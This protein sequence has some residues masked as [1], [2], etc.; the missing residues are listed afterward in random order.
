MPEFTPEQIMLRDMVR[1]MAKEKIAPLAAEIDRER[2]YPD[3][4]IV[5]LR[6]QGLFGIP[7]PEE[8]GGGGHGVL[9]SCIVVEELAKVCGNSAMVVA[10]QDLGAIPI[11]LA[12]SEEQKARYLPPLATGEQ[13]ISFALTEPEAGSDVASMRTKAEKKGNEYIINGSKRFISYADVADVMCV[14]AKTNPDGGAR[15][16]SAFIVDA[17]SPGISIGKREDKM[18]FGGFNACEVYFDDVRVPST[19]LLGGEGQGFRLAMLTLD[20]TRP[21]IGAEGVGLAEGCLE[22]AIEYSKQRIQFGRPI[23]TFQGLQFMMA[24]MAMLIEASRQLVYKAAR[25]ADADDPEMAKLGAMA[26]CFATDTAM[27]VSV[28][29]IQILGGVGYMR[30][31]PLERRMREAKL[32]QIVE[33]TN[34]IQRIVIASRILA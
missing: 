8:Y 11:L 2:Y 18:G 6:E 15:G 23:S 22:Y 3:E 10:T 17:R 5:L 32:L 34:Q 26:K 7:F 33:G 24:D 13:R 20:K 14:F 28:D 4:L 29:A 21:I 31:Y 1:R 12:G 9:S 16:I 25:A 19:N 30:D 27:K